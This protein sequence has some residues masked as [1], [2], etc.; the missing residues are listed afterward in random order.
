MTGG[1][2]H[3]ARHL[4]GIRR[5]VHG[6]LHEAWTD[7]CHICNI[8]A[9]CAMQADPLAAVAMISGLSPV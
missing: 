7:S 4:L 6:R 2:G 8:P 3:N 9:D 5:T 1:L